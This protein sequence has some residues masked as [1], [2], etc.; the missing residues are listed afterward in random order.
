VEVR[1]LFCAK[2]NFKI[3]FQNFGSCAL[4]FGCCAEVGILFGVQSSYCA[5]F[6]GI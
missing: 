6:T 2:G 5:Q 1:F 4:V 3:L